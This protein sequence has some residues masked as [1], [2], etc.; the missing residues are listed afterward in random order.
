MKT[1]QLKF[2]TLIFLLLVGFAFASCGNANKKE[3]LVESRFLKNTEVWK[4]TG[5]ANGGKGEQAEAS[6]D[7]GVQDGYIFAKDD[8]AG[9][10][11][12]FS[13]PQA[14]LGDKSNFY[15]ATLN[16][17]LFQHSAIKDQFENNDVIFKNGE[18]KITYAFKNY[19]KQ[20]WTAYSIPIDADNNWMKGNFNNEM[21]A[22]KEDIKAVLS[23]V[24]EFWI[25]G[26]YES[27]GDEGGLDEVEIT[28]N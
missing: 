4:I 2:K 5:D 7:G 10:T 22:T 17:N 13:A 20:D 14:Y 9:G 1:P 21:P 18:K 15:G 24:T 6:F 26:E 16:F 19:P 11:W 28:K 25:R 27:G 12:Y 8:A 23:N 3:A